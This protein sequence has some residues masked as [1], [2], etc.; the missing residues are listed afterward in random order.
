ML[1]TRRR[2]G[3]GATA[4]AAA[5]LLGPVALAA[6]KNAT[7][8]PA[9][10]PATLVHPEL[11]ESLKM[12]AAMGKMPPMTAETLPNI[13]AMAKNFVRPALPTPPIENKTIPGAPGQPEVPVLLIAPA[14]DGK[15]RP[16]VVFI[17]GGGY[18]L[19][20]AMGEAAQAQ[21]LAADL[22]CVVVSVDYRMAP[23]THFPGP[24]EDVYAA[25]RWMHQNAATLGVDPKR[26]AVVGGSA[27][28]GYA[29]MLAIAARDRGEFP[30]CYQVLIY[31]MLDDHTGSTHMPP[32]FIGTFGWSA[33]SN[34][35]GWTSLLGVPAGSASVPK[36][37]VP[38]REKNLA[39]LPPAFVGVGTLDLFAEED[40]TYAQRLVLAG[41]PTKMMVVPG[42][43]HGFDGMAANTRIAKEFTAAWRTEL[44]ARFAELAG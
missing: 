18:I 27:G 33:D 41:V 13:R 24:L 32:P 17:H 10:D 34:K 38:A 26:I 5:G 31:P 8:A 43:F 40:M 11:R 42:A 9:I 39:G 25:L 28:G 23:D 4:C 36:G 3:L 22:D 21:S 12:M 1:I 29:A 37:A 2:L 16:G 44:A 15:V 14:K 20:T 7:A 6:T 35:L 19:G 30:L